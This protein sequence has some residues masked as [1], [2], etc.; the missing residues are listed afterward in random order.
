M[1]KKSLFDNSL[2]DYSI[3]KDAILIYDLRLINKK[4]FIDI[5][6]ENKTK[7]FRIKKFSYDSDSI[8]EAAWLNQ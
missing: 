3:S 6:K 1:L 8:K 7:D 2:D 5:T 4:P